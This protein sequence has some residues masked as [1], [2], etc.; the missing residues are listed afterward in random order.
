MSLEVGDTHLLT[1]AGFHNPVLPGIIE[2]ELR[3]AEDLK[4]QQILMSIMLWQ[5]EEQRTLL[6]LLLNIPGRK[7]L[8]TTNKEFKPLQRSSH[9]SIV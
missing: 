7:L 5:R 9:L 2:A 1:T 4:K 3:K 8:P 6:L